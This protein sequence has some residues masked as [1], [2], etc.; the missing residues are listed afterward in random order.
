[1]KNFY[2][3]L[4]LILLLFEDSFSQ[5]V[6]NTIPPDGVILKN[7]WK[8]H[9]GDDPAWAD[10]GF[11]DNAW[12]TIN[13]TLLPHKSPEV[14][15]GG[16]GWFR[17]QLLVDSS[18]R[19]ETVFMSIS[20]LGAAEIY[21][22]GQ[23]LYSF[24]KVNRDYKKEET[25]FL[26]EQPYSLKLANDSVQTLAVRYSFNKRN[27]YLNYGTP[28]LKL[29]LHTINQGFK[30][31][32]TG[33]GF[34][35][36]LSTIQLVFFVPLGLLLLFLYFSFPMKKEYLF[37]GLY[38]FCMFVGMV[39]ESIARQQSFTVSQANSFLLIEHAVNTGGVFFFLLGINVLYKQARNWLYYFIV[40]CALLAIPSLFVSYDYGFAVTLIYYLAVSVEVLRLSYKAI[41]RHKLGSMILFISSL[42]NIIVITFIIVMLGPDDFKLFLLLRVFLY[43]TPALGLSLF[44]AVDFAHTGSALQQRLADIERL[45]IKTIEQEK[46]RQRILRAQNET[47]EK[48]VAER[49]GALSRSLKELKETQAHLIQ[50]EKMA[51]LGEL[52]AGIAHEIQN[53]LNFI[54]N[55]SDV[56]NELI[57]E[58]KSEFDAGKKDQA[59][60]IAE[61]IRENSK[62]INLHGKRADAIVKG[63]LQHSGTNTG[64]K[65]PVDINAL[66][67]ECL[68]LG[69]QGFRAKDKG[70]NVT[71]KI[72]LDSSIGT[73]SIVP[74]DI[75]RVLLNLCNN[76]FYS[77]NEKKKAATQKGENF[78][79]T[80]WVTTQHSNSHTTAEPMLEICLKDNGMGIPQKILGKIYQPFFTTKPAGQGT[81]LGLSL[82]YDIIKAHGGELRV[83]TKEGEGAAFIIELP[84][85]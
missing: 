35:A 27:L 72:E 4:F 74:Q 62:K 59:F 33:Q 53:P 55:F 61:D 41:K 77:V 70:F 44:I 75:G 31:Y 28:I 13:P 10:P 78:E 12:K 46:E 20:F 39:L 8:F 21:L 73:V 30:D 49:T 7:G 5:I 68:R 82:S 52:T 76:A 6:L 18:L 24:G 36:I 51:S 50:R 56:N 17:F 37:L 32:K 22:N 15:N 64:E 81:G 40:V 43:I 14:R 9:A 54:N 85:V 29:D 38:C 3:I 34:L 48:Q 26:F 1:M 25:R 23:R 65:Q 45:S 2:L 58:M 69:Y 47:L 57:D 66:A 42:L 71:L 63:M 80:V 67:D 83:E 84:L 11:D 16:I 60:L 79:P 19:N